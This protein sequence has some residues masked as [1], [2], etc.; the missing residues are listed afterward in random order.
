MLSANGVRSR[1]NPSL[2]VR[3]ARCWSVMMITKL[4]LRS[5]FPPCCVAAFDAGELTATAASTPAA[6]YNVLLVI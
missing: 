2:A 3:S 6:V 5:L 4:G 1:G